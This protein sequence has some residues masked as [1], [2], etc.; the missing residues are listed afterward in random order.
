MKGVTNVLRN[1]LKV[2]K[3]MVNSVTY[4]ETSEV[5]ERLDA[6]LLLDK[7]N[8]EY[9]KDNKLDELDTDDYNAMIRFMLEQKFLD[10]KKEKKM[11]SK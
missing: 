7:F 8:L 4:I 1:N 6:S 10:I 5:E 11:A 2:H 9:I 3:F